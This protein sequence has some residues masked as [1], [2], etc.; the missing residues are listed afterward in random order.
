[1]HR[2]VQANVAEYLELNPDIR[3]LFD[4]LKD[5]GKKLFLITN[6]PYNFV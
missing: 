6:S 5:N 2:L 3:K 1:M 4:R